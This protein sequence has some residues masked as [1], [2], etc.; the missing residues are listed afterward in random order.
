[1]ATVT[2][3]A[4]VDT[5]PSELGWMAYAAD[6]EN[7]V[8]LTFGHRTPKDAMAHLSTQYVRASR[9]AHWHAEA[10]TRLQAF[11]AGEVVDLSDIPVD[12]VN[13]TDFQRRV[14]E[15]CRRIPYGQTMTYGELA[16]R[17][18]APRAARAVGSTMARNELPLLIP[19]HR[20]VP[21]GQ[22]IGRYSA[23]EG[24]RTKLR[25]LETEAATIAESR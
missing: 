8:Q 9:G 16:T 3:Q 1:M 22:G 18:K 13:A 20:V 14:F 11:A 23:G 25:L 6:G 19:C 24:R 21:A 4:V 15:S 12:L 2:M 7:L 17:A 10:I 5:F